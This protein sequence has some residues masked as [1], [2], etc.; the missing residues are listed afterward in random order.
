MFARIQGVVRNYLLICEWFRCA[1][2]TR[3]SEETISELKQNQLSA[4]E[5]VKR[6]Q[7]EHKKQLDSVQS[8]HT[9]D[10]SLMRSIVARGSC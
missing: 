10:V 2:V 7:T 6:L 4:Q 1:Q 3:K 5:E 9:F 8:Q